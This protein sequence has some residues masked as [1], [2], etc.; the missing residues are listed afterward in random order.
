MKELRRLQDVFAEIDFAVAEALGYKK[1]IVR[2]IDDLVEILA[3]RRI[4]RTEKASPESIG[5]EEEPRITPPKKMKKFQKG[6]ADKQL[7]RWIG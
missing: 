3:E 2:K 6:M 4:S 1:E 5:G 7:T